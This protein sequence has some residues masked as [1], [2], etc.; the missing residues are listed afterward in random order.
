MSRV[1][2]H[3]LCAC[4]PAKAQNAQTGRHI[5]ATLCTSS[6]RFKWLRDR[7]LGGMSAPAPNLGSA[8]PAAD[9]GTS[10]W[11]RCASEAV[12]HTA[13]DTNARHFPR[14]QGGTSGLRFAHWVERVHLHQPGVVRAIARPRHSY[15]SAKASQ[16]AVLP[17]E[18]DL[19]D[20]CNLR[21]C[22]LVA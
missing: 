16:I 18:S 5:C 7:T 6:E 11:A 13:G 2:L 1:K 4:S 14:G 9:A 19:R 21:K 17:L 3:Q 12:Q 15:L 8:K 10:L 22:Y 20:V